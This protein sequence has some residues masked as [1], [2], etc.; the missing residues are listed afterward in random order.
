MKP[1]PITRRSSR[2]ARERGLP[3]VCANPDLVVDVG[4]RHYLCAGAFA[5]AYAEMG[6]EVFWAGK[7]HPSAYAAAQTK[8]EDL[9]GGPLPRERVLA[10]GDAIRT[11]MKA[12]E[13]AGVD[14]LFVTA[15]IH[16]AQTMQGA[17]IDP[18]RLA[19]ALPPGSP[20]IVAATAFL[21]W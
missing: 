18:A 9:R 5:E 4:G 11:D 10:I 3:F 8:A 20:P 14:A 12:A 6:G 17:R 21:D 15:G 1:L 13:V 7:P 2:A 19:A 16:R